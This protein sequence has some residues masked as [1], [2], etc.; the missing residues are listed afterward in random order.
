MYLT[1]MC[2]FLLCFCIYFSDRLSIPYLLPH[3]IV[4]I[5]IN[6]YYFLIVIW[7]RRWRWR[8][9]AGARVRDKSPE[10][11]DAVD[12]RQRLAQE[13]P[14]QQSWQH[15]CRHPTRASD[16]TRWLS[17]LGAN[18]GTAPASGAV[19]TL[20]WR[21][22]G[23]YVVGRVAL[24]LLVASACVA[25]QQEQHCAPCGWFEN[26]LTLFCDQVSWGATEPNAKD[27]T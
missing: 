16:L 17:R 22:H 21:R 27:V 26:K 4:W 23:W 8:C 18:A 1:F 5:Q 9:V 2:T 20:S 14:H 24:D 25:S 12:V 15:L 11:G 10:E 19:T 3:C 6:I 7:W 13:G